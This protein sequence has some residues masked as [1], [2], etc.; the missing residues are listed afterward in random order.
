MHIRF[1]IAPIRNILSEKNIV[2]FH[3][4]TVLEKSIILSMYNLIFG[5]NQ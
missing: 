3:K 2:L 5:Q 1:D 4:I